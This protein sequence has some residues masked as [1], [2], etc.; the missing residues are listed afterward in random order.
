MR[1][2]ARWPRRGLRVGVAT[3]GARAWIH[4]EGTDVRVVDLPATADRGQ[5]DLDG[6]MSSLLARE[7]RPDESA[8]I[9]LVPPLAELR[10]L[11]L[12]PMRPSDVRRALAANPG[13]Y[14]PN[15]PAPR[16]H[17]AFALPTS[18]THGHS[19]LIAT[20]S[21]PLVAA[22]LG[23][24]RAAA[25]TTGSATTGSATGLPVRRPRVAPAHVAW[26]A[27]ARVAVP[28]GEVSVLVMF[29]HASVWIDVDAQTALPAGRRRLP[30]PADASETERWLA[31]SVG[32][33]DDQTG[34]G[35]IP[36]ES[37]AAVVVIGEGDAAVG[38]VH[39]LDV[40]G[41][42]VRHVDEHPA[43]VAA[44]WVARTPRSLDLK[45]S[46]RLDAEARAT[47][48]A[49]ARTAAAGIVLIFAA[50]GIEWIGLGRELAHVRTARARLAP[51]VAEVL[52]A[53]SVAASAGALVE[54]V[55]RLEAGSP[56]WSD[57]LADLAEALPDHAHLR[58]LEAEPRAMLLDGIAE[59]GGAALAAL[60]ASPVVAGLE[61]QGPIRRRENGGEVVE[62]FTVLVEL[63]SPLEEP[64]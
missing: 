60:M 9:A 4:R 18:E 25:A 15:S 56:R 19:W 52:E 24:S 23:S 53:R 47:R 54:E 61:P 28:E 59:N 17:A 8:A 45:T 3:D 10:T 2:L 6:S 38:A 29:D 42:P 40:A 5:D 36:G 21:E 48:R 31:G 39:T 32:P 64:R 20:A 55:G 14:F 1:G 43:S 30:R 46:A 44:R 57:R 33:G 37:G 22:V 49:T 58:R 62:E 16:V 12:P 7:I 13:R 41:R 63:A 11:S 51:A 35:Q 34:S 26:A 27:A 50:L